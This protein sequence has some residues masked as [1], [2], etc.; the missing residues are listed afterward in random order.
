MQASEQNLHRQDMADIYIQT[1]EKYQHSAI[2]LHE[3]PHT[4][5]DRIRLTELVREKTGDRYFLMMHG[6][7]T[8]EIP[9][10]EHMESFIYRLADDPE[11]L[12]REATERVDRALQNAEKMKTQTTLDGFALCSDYCFNSGPFLSP[13][14]FGEFITPYLDKL[15]RGY[16][17]MGFYTIKHTDGNILP[18][19]DQLVQCH[20]HALHSL[21]PQGGVDIREVK[22][23]YGDQV[24]LIGNVHCG[25]L[26]TGTEAELERSVCYALE[27][28]APGGGYIFSTSN[29]I[30]TGMPLERYEKMLEIFRRVTG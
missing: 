12:K 20:P 7:A 8:F 17:D 24:C 21:D 19:L 25:L 4:L 9:S 3:N 6:D 29:C 27:H 10:G 28:G 11:G 30:Y 18:I 22:K 2:F 26:Q 14:Q 1:A 5:E 23:Q 16:R 15:I 13:G